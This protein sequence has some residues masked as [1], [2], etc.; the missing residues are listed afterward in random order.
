MPPGIAWIWSITAGIV[1]R[2]DSACMAGARI[3]WAI[4]P[5]VSDLPFGVPPEYAAALRGALDREAK[6][7]RALES[8]GPLAN[9][10]VVAID[11][12]PEQRARWI[13]AGARLTGVPSIRGAAARALP[14]GSADTIVSTW[15]GFRGVEPEEIADADR[16]LRP[17]GRLLVVHDYGRDDVSRLRG[18]QP[19]YGPWTR[20]DG[21]F[22]TSGFR[23][24]VIHCFWTFDDLEGAR[25]VIHAVFGP[26]ADALTATLKRP[27]L[28]WN[29]AVYHRTRGATGRASEVD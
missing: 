23:V 22:L 2:D 13:A 26:A 8:L 9:R 1:T 19:E 24:R 11:P 18:D 25:A 16:L 27:R 20:R 7:D 3:A 10:D 6:L 21:P 29:V 4:L 5:G 15:T 28:S 14:D 17:G 12:G